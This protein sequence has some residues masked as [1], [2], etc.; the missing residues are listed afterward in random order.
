MT[1][2]FYSTRGPHG[3]FSN[4]APHGV[5]IDGAYWPTVEHYFQAQKFAGTPLEEQ[6][7]HARTP[8]EAKRLGR[9]RT[10]PQRQDWEE[11]KDDLMR[12]AVLVKFETH[13]QLR[14]EL[15]AT[16]DEELAEASPNDYYWGIDTAGTG[17]NM[18][19]TILME[20][21]ATLR[22]REVDGVVGR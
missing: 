9:Q 12:R 4:F 17:K 2:Y 8:R 19:G 16:G 14:A 15:L 10:A 22:R 13:A 21:R 20:V 1:I 18:L 6:I 7:R 3:C 11:I 5:A